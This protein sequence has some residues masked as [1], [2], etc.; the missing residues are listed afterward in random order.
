MSVS[1]DDNYAGNDQSNALTASSDYWG[2]PFYNNQYNGTFDTTAA[3][4]TFDLTNWTSSFF[5]FD[6]NFQKYNQTNLSAALDTDRLIVMARANAGS[7]TTLD[8]FNNDI[9][10]LYVLN[11]GSSK[12]YDISAFDGMSNVQVGFRYIDQ[13]ANVSQWYSQVD[14]VVIR[15]QGVPEPMTLTLLGG[16]AIAGLRRRKR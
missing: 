4:A 15:A 6:V 14:N 7:W 9:G 10:Q 1:D 16:L 2:D 11:S 12:T 3:S 13:N 8:T 5:S